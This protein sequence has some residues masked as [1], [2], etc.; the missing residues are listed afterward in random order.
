M[1]VVG[2][3]VGEAWHCGLLVGWNEINMSQLTRD[4]DIVHFRSVEVTFD[5]H[6]ISHSKSLQPQLM[7]LASVSNAFKA[8]NIRVLAAN[9][10]LYWSLQGCPYFL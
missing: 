3:V 6:L 9:K 7:L 8:W 2:G 4:E 5:L 1:D 10:R